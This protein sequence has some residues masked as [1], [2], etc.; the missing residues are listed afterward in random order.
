MLDRLIER[1]DI[2]RENRKVLGLFPTTALRDGGTPRRAELIGAVRSVLVDGAEPDTR[3]AVLGAL[4][5]AS[6]SLPALHADIPWSGAVY[7]RG[8]ELEAADWGAAAA[9]E[10]VA[11]TVTAISTAA[12]LA[13]V[14]AA[15]GN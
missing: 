6:G 7:T 13:V 14:S 5:S 4:L 2:R 10:A 15:R 8:K 1:G 9:G 12:S 11:R 3:T